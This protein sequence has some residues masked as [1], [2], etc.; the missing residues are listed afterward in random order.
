VALPLTNGFVGEFLLLQGVYQ[1]N[2]WLGIIAGTTIILG[3]V[4]MLRMFQKSM[5]GSTTSLTENFTDLT[6]NE[7][8]VLL[9]LAILVVVMGVAPNF[10]LKITEPAAVNLMQL[11][12]R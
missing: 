6:F 10:L 3:A 4:Y 1:Y 7:K 2:I 11:I 12:T 8:A 5:F 9:P